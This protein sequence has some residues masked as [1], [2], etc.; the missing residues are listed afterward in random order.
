MP[1]RQTPTARPKPGWRPWLGALL[2]AIIL[3]GAPPLQPISHGGAPP[4]VK[5]DQLKAVF[6]YNFLHFVTWPA[7]HPVVGQAP[8]TMVIG[9]VGDSPVLKALGDLS[10][11][12]TEIN[13]RS[14]RIVAFGG[15]QQGMDLGACH[16]LFVSASEKGRMAEIIAS[17]GK[18]P[19]L[20]VADSDPFVSAGGMITMLEQQN[21]I[22]YHINRQAATAAGLRLSSQLLKTAIDVPDAQDK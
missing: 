6:L 11:T 18:R 20:T 7:D 2:L 3:L 9:V 17:L 22:R 12:V 13:K 21:R 15:Y 10:T 14:L 8:T 16:I 4:P 19:V 1:R 5:H